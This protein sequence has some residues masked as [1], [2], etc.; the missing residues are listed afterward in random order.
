MNNN[1]VPTYRIVNT[2]DLIPDLPSAIFFGYL[3]KHIGT[4]VDFTAQ[5]GSVSDNHSLD[6]AYD[7][8]IAHPANPQGPLPVRTLGVSRRPGVR[9]VVEGHM[10][11]LARPAAAE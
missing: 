2:E 11:R 10:T 1:G 6:I 3:Y 7:Y 5:Y 8:A 4:P 9:V